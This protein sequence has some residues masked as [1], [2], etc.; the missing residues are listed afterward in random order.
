MVDRDAGEPGEQH[1]GALIVLTELIGVGLVGEVEVAE[2]L[3]VDEHGDTEERAHPRMAGREA[4]RRRVSTDVC[5]AKRLGVG[6]QRAENAASARERPDPLAVGAVD[7]GGDEP[8]ELKSRCIEDP[9][10]GIAG[11]GQHSGRFEEFRED[12]LEVEIG[13][14]AL[15][16]FEQRFHPRQG[17][18]VQLI[19]ECPIPFLGRSRRREPYRSRACVAHCCGPVSES[20]AGVSE[21]RR[22]PARPRQGGLQLGGDREQHGLPDGA[23]DQ[24]HRG[25][26]PVVAVVERERDRRQARSR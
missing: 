5:D 18:E 26:E 8:L 25:R 2:R 6:D 3:T 16:D 22:A 23:A 14:H 10:R 11:T 15:C 20:R 19:H 1:E 24:L 13:N 9:E 12:G 17:I 7:A 21:P 4:V